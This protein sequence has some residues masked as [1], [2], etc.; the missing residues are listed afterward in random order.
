MCQENVSNVNDLGDTA[1]KEARKFDITFRKNQM[2]C[3][4]TKNLRFVCLQE[5]TKSSNSRVIIQYVYLF[6]Y[7]ESLFSKCDV[8]FKYTLFGTLEI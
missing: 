8:C 6:I 2:L 4:D 3:C 7:N 1:R 5:A